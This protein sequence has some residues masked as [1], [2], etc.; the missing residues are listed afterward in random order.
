MKLIRNDRDG[1][2]W[3]FGGSRGR[4]CT[5]WSEQDSYRHTRVPSAYSLKLTPN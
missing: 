3:F 1:G 4:S 5:S 2:V